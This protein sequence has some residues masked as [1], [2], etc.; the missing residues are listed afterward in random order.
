MFIQLAG[1]LAIVHLSICPS[2]IAK[3]LALDIMHKLLNQIFFELAMLKGTIGFYHVIPLYV[4]LTL[5][6]GHKVSTNQNLLG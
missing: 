4:M 1:W 5:A 6:L 2:C 3:T